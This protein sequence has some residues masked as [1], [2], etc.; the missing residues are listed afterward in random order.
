MLQMN[1][2]TNPNNIMNQQLIIEGFMRGFIGFYTT[3]KNVGINNNGLSPD[4]SA[5]LDVN[6]TNKGLLIPRMTTTERDAINNP[7]MSLLIFNT[8]TKCYEGY[9]AD[10]GAWFAFGCLT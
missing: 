8:D 5:I 3:G 1:N 6:S 10:A 7:V 4:A 9:N 2:L